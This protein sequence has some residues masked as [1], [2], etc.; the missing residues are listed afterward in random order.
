[1]N[2][3]LADSLRG[4]M[5][6]AVAA[7]ATS[8]ID[9]PYAHGQWK[10]DVGCDCIGLIGGVGLAMGFESARR[11]ARDPACKGYGRQPDPVMLMTALAKYMDP[12]AFD[13][14]GLGDVYLM[15]WKREPHHFAIVTNLNPCYITHAYVSARKVCETA[16]DSYWRHGTAW[17]SLIVGAWRYR[18]VSA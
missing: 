5:G 4:L 1:M 9:T 15:R 16:L 7:E 11:W 6:G 14:V 3:I 2:A 12:I 18:E 10:K 17:R 8:W 13:E